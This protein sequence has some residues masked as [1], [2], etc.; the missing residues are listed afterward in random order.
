MH[1]RK[2]LLPKPSTNNPL[3]N[4]AYPM[5]NTSQVP[6]L[7]GL[8]MRCMGSPSRSGSWMRIMKSFSK[9]ISGIVNYNI[10]ITFEQNFWFFFYAK[11][12]FFLWISKLQKLFFKIL[13]PINFF[14]SLLVKIDSVHTE[15]QRTISFINNNI[16][17]YKI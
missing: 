13:L 4:R 17:F 12:N 1:L 15:F 10:K 3:D 6:D 2:C 5:A 14:L 8:H 9:N 16:K 7:E 11:I